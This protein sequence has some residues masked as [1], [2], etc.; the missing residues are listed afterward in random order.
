MFSDGGN[1][2]TSRPDDVNNN[3]SKKAELSCLLPVQ[4]PPV[5]PRLSPVLPVVPS[6]SAAALSTLHQLTQA[7]GG[8]FILQSLT[9]RI[10]SQPISLCMCTP[11]EQSNI[12]QQ[13]TGVG[14]EQVSRR[15]T[16]SLPLDSIDSP[17]PPRR[18]Y[19]INFMVL[20]QIFFFRYTWCPYIKVRFDRL[21]L[22][23]VMDRNLTYVE[24]LLS[25]LL[26]S[27]VALLGSVLLYQ[28][29]Y[30]DLQAF[31]LCFV[32]AG[33]Q[34]SL[35]KS[36]QPDTASPTHGY[37]RIVVFSRPVYFVLVASII[38]LLHF[39]MPKS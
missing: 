20:I 26:A 32:M 13:S 15:L 28:Q 39:N 9:P 30:R 25:I 31:I 33:S 3:N 21:M 35:I 22:L 37:N 12:T 14:V 27:G 23:A 38:L 18:Y 7:P 34:Y 36:V 2:E 1:G 24:T 19:S 17:K 11:P 6:G 5:V 29:L 4:P 16:W 8:T 10:S